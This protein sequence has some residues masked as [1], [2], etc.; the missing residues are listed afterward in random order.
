MKE[1]RFGPKVPPNLMEILRPQ[2]QLLRKHK[3]KRNIVRYLGTG[4]GAILCK[5][6]S[7]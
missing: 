2:I 7:V 5:V 4:A 3:T 1:Y 6:S